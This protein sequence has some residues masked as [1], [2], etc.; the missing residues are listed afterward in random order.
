MKTLF[1]LNLMLLITAI[2]LGDIVLGACAFIGF[3]GFA[4]DLLNRKASA[5]PT[6]L[7]H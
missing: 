1:A 5:V 4:T 3:C 7:T 6:V 2:V